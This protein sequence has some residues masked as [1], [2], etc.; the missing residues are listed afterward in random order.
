MSRFKFR[1]LL[2][3]LILAMYMAI[4]CDLAKSQSDLQSGVGRSQLTKVPASLVHALEARVQLRLA[5]VK[6]Y[7]LARANGKNVEIE[8]AKGKLAKTKSD[9]MEWLNQQI[10]QYGW[11]SESRVGGNGSYHAWWIV[12]HCDDNLEFLQKCLN[13][14]KKLRDASPEQMAILTD[15]VLTLEG[16]P[17]Q[18]GTQTQLVGGRNVAKGIQA[19][20]EVDMRRASVGLGALDDALLEQDRIARLSGDQVVSK[21]LFWT[22]ERR[23]RYSKR[24]LDS[25]YWDM[26]LFQED[27]SLHNSIDRSLSPAISDFPSPVPSY[28]NFNGS[29]QWPEFKIGNRTISSSCLLWGRC[30]VNEELFS[31]RDHTLRSYFNIFVLTD[32][33]GEGT[34]SLSMAS[35]NYPHVFSSGKQTTS[36]GVVDWAHVG[37]ADGNNYALINARIFDLKFGRTI[38][39]AP[40]KNGSLRFMQLKSPDTCRSGGEGELL[41]NYVE[42]LKEKPEVI[43]FFT[44]PNALGGK[45][46]SVLDRPLDIK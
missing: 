17:Q 43:D 30:V 27:L 46:S 29:I 24:R 23:I 16:Q 40:Q 5:A 13:A 3:T 36:V 8:N 26:M 21:E 41:K 18:Y 33:S 12:D 6:G 45:P 38:L 37:F 9:N 20:N 4:C 42:V 2:V 7:N 10:E 22:P 35:R 28:E 19:S 31:N 15:R 1:T 25:R 11:L 39:V 34:K 44:S 14:M 32:R